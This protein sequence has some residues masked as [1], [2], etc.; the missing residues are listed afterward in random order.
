MKRAVQYEYSPWY[1]P[2]ETMAV[3]LLTK[4]IAR[5]RLKV[6]RQQSGLQQQAALRR[7]E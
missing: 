7:I 2:S 1:S 5:L 6:L 4:P 3:D